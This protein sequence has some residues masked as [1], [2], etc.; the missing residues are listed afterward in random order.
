MIPLQH[1]NVYRM[2]GGTA[3][4]LVFWGGTVLDGFSRAGPFAWADWM[5]W[6]AYRACQRLGFRLPWKQAIAT[7]RFSCTSKNIP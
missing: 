7:I 2:A 4:E 5:R 6:M 3:F 1:F